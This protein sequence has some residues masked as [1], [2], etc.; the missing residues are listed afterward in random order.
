MDD[1]DGTF[2]LAKLDQAGKGSSSALKIFGSKENCEHSTEYIVEVETLFDPNLYPQ[3]IND[4]DFNIRVNS[5]IMDQVF[6]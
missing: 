3:C 5:V 2:K 6:K 1:L 4:K